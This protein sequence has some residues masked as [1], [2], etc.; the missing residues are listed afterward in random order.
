MN[1]KCTKLGINIIIWGFGVL[2]LFRVSLEE[3]LSGIFLKRFYL[4]FDGFLDVIVFSG[5]IM[6]KQPL[7][8][9]KNQTDN[10]V[11]DV[12]FNAKNVD[13]IFEKCSPERTRN[14]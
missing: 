7:D 14:N 8:L 13:N 1:K 2:L 11:F 9:G 12:Y 6:Q 3:I 4:V 5:N 10:S